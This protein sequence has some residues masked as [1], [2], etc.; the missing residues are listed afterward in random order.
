MGKAHG[1]SGGGIESRQVSNVN[2]PK[3]ELM[4]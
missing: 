1:Y 2:A 4:V 3:Q